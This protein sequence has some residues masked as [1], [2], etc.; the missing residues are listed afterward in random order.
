MNTNKTDDVMKKIE[1][2]ERKY[3]EKHPGK[4]CSSHNIYH[5]VSEDLDGNIT[6]EAFGINV[7][8]DLGF[9]HCFT[10]GDSSEGNL[11]DLY[12]GD[13][14]FQTIDPTSSS[15][16]NIISTT[17]A[18]KSND[19]YQP[20]WQSNKWISDKHMNCSTWKLMECWFNYTVWSVD[21]EIT[22]LGITS[23]KYTG[24]N[25]LK[26]HAAIYDSE[27]QKSSFWKRVNEKLTITVYG[28][29][30]CPIEKV[31]NQSW[32]R[33][34]PCAIR[35]DT[36]TQ[37]SHY[38]YNWEGNKESHHTWDNIWVRIFAYN[39]YDNYGNSATL[40]SPTVGSITD[41]IY[42][43]NANVST[44]I[45]LDKRYQYISDL[46]FTDLRT[47]YD[48]DTALYYSNFIFLS[49]IKA[50][51]PIP[52]EMEFFRTQSYS[53]PTLKKT[54]CWYND[55]FDSYGYEGMDG[56]RSTYGQL[57][58]TNI[59]IT[60]LT[61]YNG[62]TD[63]WDI[64][65]PFLEPIQYLEHGYN[66]LRAS[67]YEYG[68]I[69]FLDEYKWFRVY[70]NEAP[71]Y[72]IKTIYNC[73][74]TMYT[75]DA[76]WDTSTWTIVQNN[77]AIS[78][79]QGDKR[80]FITF[81]EQFNSTSD[82]L[83]NFG[84][85]V[86]TREVLRYDYEENF[87][88]LNLN[89]GYGSDN[90]FFGAR[91]VGDYSYYAAEYIYP[92]TY[93][94][95]AG[96]AIANETYGYIAQ[97]GFLM[98]PDT[99]DPNPA[100]TNWTGTTHS[101]N[102]QGV[103]YR[104]TIGGINLNGDFPDGRNLDGGHRCLIWNTTRG[105]HI[106]CAGVSTY[107]NGCRVY[108]VNIDPSVAPTYQDFQYDEAFT[109]KPGWS[110]TDNGYL[111]VSY[112]AGTGNV[113]DTY[114]LKYDVTGEA[115][116]MYKVHGYRR[117]FA[118]DLTNYFVAI[119]PSVTGHLGLVIYDMANEEVVDTIDDIPEGYTFAGFAGWKNFIYI[120]VLQ[121]GTYSTFI[122]YINERMLEST[123]LDLKQMDW[124]TGS[125]H[126]HIQRAVEGSGNIESCMILFVSDGY[127]YYNSY[128]HKLFRESEPTHPIDIIYDKKSESSSMIYNQKA[129]LGY[130]ADKK[131]LLAAWSTKYNFVIDIS[132]CLNHGTQTEHRTLGD[133]YQSS[134]D[135]YTPIY[136]KGFMYLLRL[137][138][139]NTKY[140]ESNY[141]SISEFYRYPYQQWMNLKI[142]GSTY[143]PNPMMNPVRIQGQ[144][145]SAHYSATNRGVDTPDPYVPP[146]P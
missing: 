77:S 108:T 130:T 47:Y 114:V 59:H 32:D 9:E 144:I 145:G 113:D 142:V 107:L 49:K 65:V 29:C 92:S 86:H 5:L 53:T 93:T 118:I 17:P 73:N 89:N 136:Y 70:I 46:Y 37:L 109:E 134:Y 63:A 103:P 143:T 124:D 110:N 50:P 87:P 121:A 64:N 25:N 42:S 82:Y 102:L 123:P 26:F 96:K 127:E 125:Y 131:Q 116:S 99:V 12:A 24:V 85:G 126:T 55:D 22:E 52:F 21:H 16:V 23:R 35:T 133:H 94:N 14:V 112:M 44:N 75:T 68:Y 7:M 90:V 71:Q 81:D 40:K 111:V 139:G 28:R 119:D 97:N 13:G 137:Y 122:Y 36:M 57:P 31:V 129:W 91:W 45:F 38:D 34:I 140:K 39:M 101:A 69:S 98:Y 120:R 83:K 100:R 105:E 61:M 128:T 18:S 11:Q 19:Y 8:T 79:S 58:M 141:Y 54:Y 30:M 66:F 74:S 2:F 76:Y 132:W 15:M 106:V 41:H 20:K 95:Y 78:R 51:N 62:Q 117:A 10:T 1:E 43:S 56:M 67:I 3:E 138:F 80:Y 4:S 146:S 60:S 135:T 48:V 33:G 6:G 84:D 88:K 27:G 72:P 104:Y 115:V